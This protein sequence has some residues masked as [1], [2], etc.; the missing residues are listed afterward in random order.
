[1]IITGVPII[2]N[3]WLD[4]GFA[5]MRVCNSGISTVGDRNGLVV[6]AMWLR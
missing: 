2:V 3:Y 4:H 1:M 6:H 5:C